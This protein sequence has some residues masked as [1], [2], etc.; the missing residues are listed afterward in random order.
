[1]LAHARLKAVLVQAG[2]DMALAAARLFEDTQVR[3]RE[4]RYT[5]GRVL[6]QGLT[7]T[8]YHARREHETE[9]LVPFP[10]GADTFAMKVMFVKTGG[11]SRRF[12]DQRRD[13]ERELQFS[14][15]AEALGVGPA[16]YDW[17]LYMYDEPEL[18]TLDPTRDVY[19][20][21]SEYDD[22]DEPPRVLGYYFIV[23]EELAVRL[24][25][26][27]DTHPL[28]RTLI[29][30]I[31]TA[32]TK[33]VDA[34]IAHGDLGAQNVM[35]D[36][37]GRVYVIDY[38]FATSFDEIEDTTDPEKLANAKKSYVANNLAYMLGF[39]IQYNS[40]WPIG[41]KSKALAVA[42]ELFYPDMVPD[43]TAVLG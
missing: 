41:S 28:T 38:G 4:P 7:A 40:A 30:D 6:G 22:E 31:G 18:A 29:A 13:V 27:L 10:E 16:V 1:M 14:L 17:G 23:I 19:H 8:V 43:T 12:Q 2:G 5:V 35:L 32:F 24:D 20:G 36:H 42:K 15:E 39:T 26:Y 25:T 37:A 3:E 11:L 9:P 34:G 21:T 33:L